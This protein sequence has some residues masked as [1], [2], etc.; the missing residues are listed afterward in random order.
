[1]VSRLT[2]N[3]I[4]PWRHC[5]R[6]SSD[7]AHSADVLNR[8]TK[9]CPMREHCLNG[10]IL[11]QTNYRVWTV[12]QAPRGHKRGYR[13]PALL[14]VLS[15]AFF[16]SCSSTWYQIYEPHFCS[17][18][19]ISAMTFREST[20]LN[21]K[22]QG[23]AWFRRWASGTIKED[24]CEPP[25]STNHACNHIDK[26]LLITQFS[27]QLQSRNHD[28]QLGRFPPSTAFRKRSKANINHH[29]RRQRCHAL[30]WLVIV[31]FVV[32][33]ILVVV[34]LVKNQSWTAKPMG[35]YRAG[36][37]ILSKSWFSCEIFS[38]RQVVVV[39]VS[40]AARQ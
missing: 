4:Q 2:T 20:R 24:R 23:N 38:A 29:I 12:V 33:I 25:S 5:W 40:P 30:L 13:M 16:N 15:K 17:V 9:E 35:C 27:A 39:V 21:K 31:V 28:L 6:C 7:W 11:H 1:M 8:R 22:S 3:Q 32:I 34:Q 26:L 14:L 19:K 18:G 36:S 10:L 37:S